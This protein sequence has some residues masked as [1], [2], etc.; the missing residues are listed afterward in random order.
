VHALQDQFTLTPL[1]AD[2]IRPVA[3]GVPEPDPR[4]TENLRW[5]EAFRVEL[6][7]F[8]PPTADAPRLALAGA[9]G[10]TASESPY[11]DPDP[12]LA[13]A[14]VAGAKAGREQIEALAKGGAAAASGWTS[15]MHAF[16]YNTDYFGVGTIDAPEWRIDDRKR[17]CAARAAAARAGLYGN[18]G[19]EADDE[20][21]YVDA[22]GEQLNGSHR[23]ELRLNPMPPVDAFWSLTMYS[24]PR[25][26]LV[27]NKL[28]RYSIGDRTPGLRVAE[29]GSL[30]IYLQR[31]SPGADKESNWLPTP[32]GDFRPI[33]RM[34][35]PKPAVLTGNYVLPAIRRV[36]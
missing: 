4:V 14:L 35:Q 21:V 33:M 1:S 32:T 28:E 30:S 23:Y 27:S 15:A 36:G 8:P 31:E 20:I 26:L 10:L 13:D 11:L 24:V 16:D 5:W 6:A 3:V 18:H 2:P 22:D 19:Y 12:E 9:F 7:A 34:Y 17:A 25:F 29:D